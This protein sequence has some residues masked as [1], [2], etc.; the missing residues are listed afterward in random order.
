MPDD[1]TSGAVSAADTAG[2][3]QGVADEF[4]TGE[5]ALL[6]IVAGA[7]LAG[8]TGTAADRLTG[9]RTFRRKV[10]QQVSQIV[11]RGS[12]AARR[13]LDAAAK[14]GR[15][16][17]KA[18]VTQR[19]G[20]PAFDPTLPD[21]G[22]PPSLSLGMGMSLADLRATAP[23]GPR[24]PRGVTIRTP[25][26][27]LPQL[28]AMEP[29]M[30]RAAEGLY[31]QVLAQVLA[32]PMRSDAQRLRLAQQLLDRAATKGLTGYI[33]GRERKWSMVSY[34]EMATR[35]AA[36]QSAIDAHTALIAANGFDL[37]RVSV[38]PNC[39][40]LCAPFQG[41]LLSVTGATTSNG[42][43][44]WRRRVVTS[45]ADARA[46]GFNHPN[47]KHFV[48]LWVPGDPLPSAP[49][50][51]PAHYKAE[52]QL[53]GLERNLRAARRRQAVA[54]DDAARRKAAARV[55]ELRKQIVAHVAAHDTVV[56]KPHREQYGTA[57]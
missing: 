54:L 53:R 44:P 29:Q 3:E 30:I 20:R 25:N 51:D 50:V 7:V 17:A 8:I 14:V 5:A 11:N 6:G 12:S 33:D 52:Q 42:P 21:S 4:S 37:V 47:C 36:A 43:E 55:V 1:L 39:S 35:T 19:T 40:N 41:H 56:R 34:V 48:Q 24:G 38:H 15:R 23:R 18:T 9:L 16:K 46:R 13:A 27:L 22:L 32:D 49:E 31:Q 10:R 2:L 28:R 45:L 26:A 57:L